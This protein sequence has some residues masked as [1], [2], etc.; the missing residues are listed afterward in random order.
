MHSAF[1]VASALLVRPEGPRSRGAWC[2][3]RKARRGLRVVLSVELFVFAAG[4][5]PG[6]PRLLRAAVRLLDAAL[7][8]TLGLGLL[9]LGLRGRELFLGA[10][11]FLGQVRHR[12]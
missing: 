10:L 2:R 7:S 6:R 12:R 11:V 5:S 4:I 9:L 1:G 8:L 3:A